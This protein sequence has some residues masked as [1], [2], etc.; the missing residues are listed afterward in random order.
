MMSELAEG[1]SVVWVT[2]NFGYAGTPYA[3]HPLSRF[4][5]FVCYELGRQKGYDYRLRIYV[6][7][8]LP[9]CRRSLAKECQAEVYRV[10]RL[11]LGDNAVAE[12][13]FEAGR[14]LE[15]VGWG[16]D[17]WRREVFMSRHTSLMLLQYLSRVNSGRV[18][19]D[20]MEVIASLA[21]RFSQIV[22]GLAVFKSYLYGAYHGM[23]SRTAKVSL[24]NCACSHSRSSRDCSCATPRGKASPLRP[25][26][27]SQP[28]TSW[29]TTGPS[30]DW[31][32]G[33]SE[34]GGWCEGRRDGPGVWCA[35]PLRTD[36]WARSLGP[37]EW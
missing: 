24:D 2:G 37:R 33:S 8:L 19:V 29:S 21:E 11:L 20:D 7:D 27:S 22:P 5:E 35:R 34:L 31:G 16:I 25:F 18:R 14:R 32:F 15:W 4:L 10:I 12:D 36:L 26:V 17:L 23:V 28:P 30:T 3:F 9:V 1:L 13:K 6:D